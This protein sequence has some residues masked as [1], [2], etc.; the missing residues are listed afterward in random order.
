MVKQAQI[1]SGGIA[2]HFTKIEVRAYAG[3]TPCIVNSGTAGVKITSIDPPAVLETLPLMSSGKKLRD[4][5]GWSNGAMLGYGQTG[6][7]TA[8]SAAQPVQKQ[9]QAFTSFTAHASVSMAYT[10]AR[11]VDPGATGLPLRIPAKTA[12]VI[13][14]AAGRRQADV[15]ATLV[16]ERAV[17]IVAPKA[18]TVDQLPPPLSAPDV[19]S[20]FWLRDIDM[21]AVAAVTTPSAPLVSA[22]LPHWTCHHEYQQPARPGGERIVAVANERSYRRD[23][24]RDEATALLLLSCDIPR[25]ERDLMR[26]WAV[27]HAQDICSALDHGTRF[28]HPHSD[29]GLFNGFKS[30]VVMG[31]LLTGDPWLAGWAQRTDWAIEDVFVRYVDQTMIDTFSAANG[32]TVEPF[33]QSDLGVPWWFPGARS[34]RSLSKAN[35]IRGIW[36]RGYQQ[37]FHAHMVAA[38]ALSGLWPGFWAMWNNQAV[39]DYC[40]R[41]HYRTLYNGSGP[42]AK[43]LEKPGSGNSPSKWHVE[44]FRAYAPAPAWDWA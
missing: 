20:R 15:R 38:H 30:A 43:G 17:V 29:S 6:L 13:T 19:R 37:M 35:P 40:D 3:G 34:Y 23:A 21:D 2:F 7:T 25:A 18:P 44:M 28:N 42:V 39:Q 11:N 14:K 9:E 27:I 5:Q 16:Q 22:V 31:A 8:P 32:Y 10:A 26:T 41:M 36:R 4:V 1:T 24:A 33:L 12:A